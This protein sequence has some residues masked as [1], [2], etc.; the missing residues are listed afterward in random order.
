MHVFALYRGRILASTVEQIVGLGD[1]FSCPNSFPKEV[2]AYLL[3]SFCP[4]SGKDELWGEQIGFV[5]V[6]VK[7][8][9]MDRCPIIGN[10]F[11]SQAVTPTTI[12]GWSL[13]W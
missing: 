3:S 1:L 9:H 7:R 10:A 13:Q 11:P 2:V 12:S 8:G 5:A 4:A 6:A